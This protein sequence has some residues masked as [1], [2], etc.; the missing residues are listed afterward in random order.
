MGIRAGRQSCMM[1]DGGM[2][3]EAAL[4]HVQTLASPARRLLG[5]EGFRM[6]PESYIELLDLMLSLSIVPIPIEAAARAS[7]FVAD[8]AADDVL[9]EIVS[10]GS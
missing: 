7:A 3:G 1:I 5:I 10:D 8:Y 4:A 9:F 2:T 6:V